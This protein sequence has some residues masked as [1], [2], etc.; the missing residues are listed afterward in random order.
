MRETGIIARINNRYGRIKNSINNFQNRYSKP[1]NVGDEGVMF[2]H[3]KYIVIAYFM[4]LPIPLIVLLI[5]NIIHKFRLRKSNKENNR[6]VY[7]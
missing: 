4:F 6:I 3:V 2:E 7:T 5:E 1:Y